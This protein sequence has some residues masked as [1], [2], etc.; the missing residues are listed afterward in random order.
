MSSGNWGVGSLVLSPA[1]PTSLRLING[2]AL[3][4]KSYCADRRHHDSIF[5]FL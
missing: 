3:E 5:V 4:D 2:A 1:R